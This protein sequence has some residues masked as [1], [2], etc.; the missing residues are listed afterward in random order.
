M[1]RENKMGK[2]VPLFSAAK[3]NLAQEASE[4]E[5]RERRLKA[6]LQETSNFGFSSED[7][8]LPI[9]DKLSTGAAEAEAKSPIETGLA[10]KWF[11]IFKDYL[12]LTFTKYGR[13]LT[14]EKNLEEA[15]R[16]AVLARLRASPGSFL[17]V[18]GSEGSK[19]LFEALVVFSPRSFEIGF[20]NLAF[21]ESYERE[22]GLPSGGACHEM[23]V[24][25]MDLPLAWLEK[26]Q[27]P[28]AINRTLV[29]LSHAGAYPGL[30]NLLAERWERL[31]VAEWKAGK[32]EIA[33]DRLDAILSCRNFPDRFKRR[34]ERVYKELCATTEMRGAL[35][36]MPSRPRQGGVRKDGAA[37]SVLSFPKRQ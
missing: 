22:K 5:E 6:L 19:K 33:R 36:I 14:D 21:V 27:H 9:L 8:L 31:A 23:L 32:E 30:E 13:G 37:S 35:S 29:V 7:E 26:T 25:L 3:K 12:A 20:S 11:S 1:K 17:D 24:R 15:L 34:A 18:A 28:K 16:Q 2:I 4:A 10:E